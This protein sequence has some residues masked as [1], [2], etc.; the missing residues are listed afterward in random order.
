MPK[1]VI[2]SAS[3]PAP[4][5]RLF[6]MYLDPAQHAAFTGSPVT[7]EP[8]T[9]SLFHAFDGMISGR[10]LHIEPTRLIVQTWRATHWPADAI[11]SVL[12][13][14]FNAEGRDSRIDVVHAN[15]CDD[16]FEGVS[17]GWSKFY[18]NPWRAFL[19]DRSQIGTGDE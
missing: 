18:W 11:D 12:V 10:M 6:E 1:T 14:T 7:I 5:D 9:G 15:V 13:L 4:P 3:L 2:Q 16:D 8:R 17:E 19:T